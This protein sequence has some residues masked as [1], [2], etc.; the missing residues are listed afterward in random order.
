MKAFTPLP[1]HNPSNIADTT[2]S[3]NAIRIAEIIDIDVQEP[4][5][6]RS[7]MRRVFRSKQLR[8]RRPCSLSSSNLL[9]RLMNPPTVFLTP[10]RFEGERTR[11]FCIECQASG[12]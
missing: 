8:W 3:E 9:L 6:D 5:N 10:H 12:L 7:V 2:Q 11:Q 1:A 4:P